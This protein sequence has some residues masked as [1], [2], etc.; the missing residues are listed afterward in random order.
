MVISHKFYANSQGSENVYHAPDDVE[1]N[2]DISLQN[3]GLDYG[4]LVKFTYDPWY[5][6]LTLTHSRPFHHAL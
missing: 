3:L 1:L 5:N 4:M 6:L 2:L